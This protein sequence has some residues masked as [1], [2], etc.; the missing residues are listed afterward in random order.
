MSKSKALGKK[1]MRFLSLGS[2]K[3]WPVE[4]IKSC[5]NQ[6]QGLVNQAWDDEVVNEER[7]KQRNR[8]SERKDATGAS[9]MFMFAS[10][11]FFPKTKRIGFSKRL[12]ECL[13]SSTRQ[14]IATSLPNSVSAAE[15][16][17]S[18]SIHEM[19]PGNLPISAS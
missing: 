8:K 1:T 3:S 17:M 2:T 14:S 11:C 19:Q 12:P 16:P 18:I 5:C 6:V 9:G 4:K 13:P 15:A 10:T 7:W